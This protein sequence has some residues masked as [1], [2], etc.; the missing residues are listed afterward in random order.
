MA[1][2]PLVS[3]KPAELKA[4]RQRL[5][6]SQKDMAGALGV[7]AQH[8]RKLEGGKTPIAHVYALACREIERSR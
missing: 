6:L 4:C 2:R 8:Y 7:T 5:G 1:R 3:V